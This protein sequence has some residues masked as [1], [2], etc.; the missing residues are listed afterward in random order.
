MFVPEV[1]ERYTGSVV[2]LMQFGAFVEVA[3]GKEAMIHISKL[4]KDHVEKVEDVVNI[5]DSTRKS[6]RY[7]P[8]SR[9]YVSAIAKKMILD[10]VLVLDVF[11]VFI[12]NLLYTYLNQILYSTSISTFSMD[13]YP[14]VSFSTSISRNS[15]ICPPNSCSLPTKG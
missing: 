2:R 11:V 10:L 15:F 9:L 14:L 1:G 5:G 4:S 6:F 12:S 8:S 13:L 3:P 7:T